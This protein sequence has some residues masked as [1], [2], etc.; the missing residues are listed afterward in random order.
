[1]TSVTEITLDSPQVPMT[2]EKTSILE[3]GL[4]LLGSY[5]ISL[6]LTSAVHELGHGLALASIQINF[7]LVLNPFSPSKTMPLQTVPSTSLAFVASAG[8]VM[9]ILFGTIVIA[10]LWRWRTPLLLPLLMVAPTAYLSSA[11]YYLIGPAIPEGDTALMISMGVPAILV[12]TLGVLMLIFGV[13]LMILMFPVLSLSPEDS[14]KRVFSILFLG[15]VLHG[16]GMIAFALLL[17]PLEVYIGIANVISM[18]V[19]IVVLTAIFFRSGH[20]LER[21]NHSEVT[22]LKRNKV[23]FIAGLALIFIVVELIFLN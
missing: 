13:I 1:M 22:P 21:I 3:L 7:R 2:S 11:G 15:M 5:V 8:T 12:Q 4:F 19:T 18:I 16:F 23:L 6:L 10:I 9:E 17:N 14:F 20:F